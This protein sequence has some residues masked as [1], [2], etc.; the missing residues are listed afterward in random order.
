MKI[1]KDETD[2]STPRLK[3]TILRRGGYFGERA[4]VEPVVRIATVTALSA[5]VI[6]VAACRLPFAAAYVPPPVSC[7]P[8]LTCR[9]LVAR[10]VLCRLPFLDTIP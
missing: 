4:L 8:S 3:E 7:L 6:K 9:L 2:P 10:H 5:Q 1:Q